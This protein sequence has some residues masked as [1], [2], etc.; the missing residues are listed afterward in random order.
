[1]IQPLRRDLPAFLTPARWLPYGADL[2]CEALSRAGAEA[3]GTFG[4]AQPVRYS[5]KRQQ[6]GNSMTEQ[7]NFAD[8]FTMPTYEQWVAEVEKVLKGA[9]FDKRMYTKTYEGVTLRPIYARQSELAFFVPAGA[10]AGAEMAAA[11]AGEWEPF[12]AS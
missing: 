7:L 4:G 3:T 5:I 12:S 8:G 10:D 2:K 11:G 1:M 9:P 6:R